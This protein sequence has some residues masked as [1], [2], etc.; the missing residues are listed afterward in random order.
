MFTHGLLG[1]GKED[2]VK[3]QILTI[4]KQLAQTAREAQG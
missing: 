2:S 1:L 4:I 3:L